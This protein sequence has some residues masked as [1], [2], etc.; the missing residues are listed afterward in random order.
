MKSQFLC[1]VMS[2]FGRWGWPEAMEA[3]QCHPG[4]FGKDCEAQP[5]LISPHVIPQIQSDPALHRSSVKAG[6]C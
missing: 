5:E 3:Q 4:G 2:G 1:A 6:G